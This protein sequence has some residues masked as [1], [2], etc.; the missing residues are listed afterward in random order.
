MSKP[1]LK[2]VKNFQLV[3]NPIDT[4]LKEIRIERTYIVK[5]PI[6][7][8]QDF[9][10]MAKKINVSKSL[11]SR[12]A[13]L[14]NRITLS[15]NSS[16]NSVSS[17]LDGIMIKKLEAVNLIQKQQIEE[18]QRKFRV[19][20][21]LKTENDELK[22]QII[23]LIRKEVDLNEEIGDLKKL[24]DD[25]YIENCNLKERICAMEGNNQET[26]DSLKEE[27]KRL[28]NEVLFLKI[29]LNK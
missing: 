25:I 23:E 24:N 13:D 14:V 16:A 19:F 21:D 18:L 8:K 4:P 27:V 20:T 29:H 26:I 2:T 9:M 3:G 22:R 15:K 5:K 10:H 7:P 11:M 28:K 12:D 17:N 1:T 6:T